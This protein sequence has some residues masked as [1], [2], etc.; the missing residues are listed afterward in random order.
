M[1]GWINEQGASKEH[2]FVSILDVALFDPFTG[3]FHHHRG[4][5]FRYREG[6][7]SSL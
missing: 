5:I 2:V 6:V 1:G 4:D 7:K 3:G